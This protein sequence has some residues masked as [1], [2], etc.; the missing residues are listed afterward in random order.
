MKTRIFITL[1]CA[2]AAFAQPAP[3]T[4]KA[5][6]GFDRKHKPVYATLAVQSGYIVEP[7]KSKMPPDIRWNGSAFVDLAPPVVNYMVYGKTATYGAADVGASEIKWG[8]F[9]DVS[10][11][12]LGGKLW[13]VSPAA[14][15]AG[16]I[17][18]K[19]LDMMGI[20]PMPPINI[21]AIREAHRPK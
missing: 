11:A 6:T 14:L 9:Q 3:Q 12:V 20:A 19:P 8:P 1:I 21:D 18:D 7:L 17:D 16:V 13:I 5:R 15:A 10:F 2:S 4:I